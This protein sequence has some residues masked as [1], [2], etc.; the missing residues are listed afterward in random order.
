VLSSAESSGSKI[1]ELAADAVRDIARPVV[2]M[3]DLEQLEGRGHSSRSVIDVRL[4]KTSRHRLQ[5][6]EHPFPNRSR[7]A[8]QFN[9]IQLRG[10]I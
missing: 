4:L 6:F 8:L 5:H 9:S 10:L 1:G 3:G 7:H 2:R